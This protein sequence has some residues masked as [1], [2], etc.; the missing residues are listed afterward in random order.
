MKMKCYGK[1]GAVNL[2]WQV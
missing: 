2:R 1:P